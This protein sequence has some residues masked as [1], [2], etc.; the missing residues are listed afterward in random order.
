M[1]I[2]I[3]EKISRKAGDLLRA[4]KWR[5]AEP[6]PGEL[7]RELAK[8]DA[9]IVRSAVEV[10]A[11]LLGLC[12]R[13][14][15]VGRAGVGVD[16]VDLDAAT[17]RGVL[18]LNTPGG[19]AVSV[20]E[21]TVA[22]M[23]AL[24]R[25][26]PQASQSLREGR[27]EKKKFMGRELRGKTLGIVGLGRIGVEVARR[28]RALEMNVLAYD[29]FVSPVMAQQTGNQLTSLK[30]LY[31]R[32]D[33]LTLH[34]SLSAETAG[35][36]DAA[37]LR[38]TKPGIRLIN[39]A[40]GELVDE[41]ALAD[42]IQSGRVAG[43][44]LD[45][46]SE[47]PLPADHCLARL[48][49]VI[50]TPHIAGSTEEAQEIVGI[51]IAEQVREYLKNSIIVN[52]VNVP[53]PSAEEYRILEPYLRL[54]ESLGSFAAQIAEGRA[55]GVRFSFS[56]KLAKMNTYMLRNSVLKG[57]LNRLLSER[58]NV[59]N[60]AALAAERGLK[61]EESGARETAFTDAMRV[62]LVTDAG[63]SSAEAALLYGTQPRLLATDGIHVEA[64]LQGHLIFMKNLD[65]PGVIGKVG[66][67]LGRRKI[68]IANFSLGRRED[69]KRPAEAV[70]VVHVDGRVPARVLEELRRLPP[71]KYV[72]S[73]EI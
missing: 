34:V 48:P 20:A 4:E 71:V 73:V 56:G 68:N 66:T 8:A 13:L 6:G 17:R 47:E 5:V 64:P 16:N 25:S 62:S 38:K 70:A 55:R 11:A 23:L 1:K 30:E 52:A 59:V 67:T 27:W 46:F 43:A 39:C 53:A 33:Y 24:A 2:V 57:I 19:N 22:L 69:G 21:H 14:R 7:A 44:A 54:A 36:I 12:P 28:A 26:I 63:E 40:R 65:L 61:L 31:A 10:N 51:R 45:V 37:A 72:R 29:P 49:Q 18:V 50:C 41:K 9:L 15:V 60:A 32:S 3:A 58:A 35:M 42:A